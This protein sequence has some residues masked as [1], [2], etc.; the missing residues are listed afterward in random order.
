MKILLFSNFALPDS[1]ADATR[2][3]SFAK[4]LG[5]LGHTCQLLGVCY[6][7]N[8]SLSGSYDGIDYEML[9]A[10]NWTGLHAHKRI[11]QLK[12]DIIAYL[13]E[14]GGY[15]A[16]L[17]S[18]IY[19]DYADVFL[20]YA[21][22]TGTRLLIN[23]LEWYDRSNIQFSGPLGFVKLI[24]NRIAL[25][26]FYKKMEVVAISSLLDDYY[27]LSGCNTVTIPTILDTAKYEAVASVPASGDE[28][29]KIAYAGNPGRKDYIV[30]AIRALELLDAEQRQRL[31]LHFYG[32]KEE[33]LSEAGITPE[34]VQRYKKNIVC[35]GRIPHERVK[36]EIAGADFTVLLRPNKRYANAGFPTKVGESM[37]CGTPVIA[38][39]TSDLHKYIIDGQTGIVCADETPESCAEAF[40]KALAM[41]G[42]QRQAMHDNCLKMAKEAF[43]YRVYVDAMEEFL[44]K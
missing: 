32:P 28:V 39:L 38:N 5:E 17:L 12:S 11:T 10:K 34:F 8:V 30:N 19:Y 33:Q 16:I 7:E 24:K 42:E 15:D 23:A 29:V 44:K 1:C 6:Q 14:H 4:L 9:Q 26:V 20:N 35:H 22:K 40:R 25:R 2:V 3:I 37:A 27:K 21:R 13:A 43:D 41:T 18:N 36:F 31:Q